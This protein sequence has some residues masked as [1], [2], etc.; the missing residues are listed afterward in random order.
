M[1]S[2][3]SVDEQS[4]VELIAA[5]APGVV[6][7]HRREVVRLVRELEAAAGPCSSQGASSTLRRAWGDLIA[8]FRVSAVHCER[9]EL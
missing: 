2:S 1:S 6:T 7:R 9:I 5:L 4:G 8:D 3:R